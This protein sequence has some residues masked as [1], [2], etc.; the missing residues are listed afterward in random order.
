MEMNDFFCKIMS[1]ANVLISVFILCFTLFVGCGAGSTDFAEDLGNGYYFYSNSSLDRFIAPKTWNDDTPIIPSKVVR[2]KKQNGY[3]IAVR[4]IIIMGSTGSR[5]A[6]GDL[7][8]WLL[9]TSL[10]RVWGPMS[11][12]ELEVQLVRLG[13]TVERP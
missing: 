4:E 1:P 5:I 11:K 13:T 8:Y 6:T 10:P 7:D 3:V 2:Y 12:S 9:D